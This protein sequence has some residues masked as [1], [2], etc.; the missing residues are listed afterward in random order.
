MNQPTEQFF[1]EGLFQINKGGRLVFFTKAPATPLPDLSKLPEEIV[2]QILTHLRTPSAECIARQMF[3]S[4]G[5]HE[6]F[7]RQRI[8]VHGIIWKNLN[9]WLI[10][11]RIW[12]TKQRRDRFYKKEYY[13]EAREYAGHVSHK[14]WKESRERVLIYKYRMQKQNDTHRPQSVAETAA[15]NEQHLSYPGKSENALEA[16]HGFGLMF[17]RSTAVVIE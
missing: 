14:L 4:S 5:E 1:L 7:Y 15:G 9:G 2:R 8:P 12:F 16:V 10:F 6:T 17:N 3:L 13:L 11:R